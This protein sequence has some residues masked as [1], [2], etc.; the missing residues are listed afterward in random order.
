MTLLSDPKI[1]TLKKKYI[2]LIVAEIDDGIDEAFVDILS[3]LSSKKRISK[4]GETKSEIYGTKFPYLHTIFSF[5]PKLPI[6][7]NY[8]KDLTLEFVIQSEKCLKDSDCSTI[9]SFKTFDNLTD[10]SFNLRSLPELEVEPYFTETNGEEREKIKKEWIKIF[11]ELQ[12]KETDSETV[13]KE[14]ETNFKQIFHSVKVGD[15]L[16]KR[17]KYVEENSSNLFFES[18]SQW[19]NEEVFKSDIES[20][21]SESFNSKNESLRN[22]RHQKNRINLSNLYGEDNEITNILRL[23]KDGKLKYQIIDSNVFPPKITF[24]NQDILED[25]VSQELIKMNYP[26]HWSQDEAEKNIMAMGGKNLNFHFGLVLIQTIWLREHNLVCDLLK[27]ENPTWND[28]RLFQTAR[29]ILIGELNKCV[30][31]DFMNHILFE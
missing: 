27:K 18:F 10:D 6:T 15:S 4:L 19:F 17:K 13:K 28:E 7:N 5:L 1:P 24:K 3:K 8:V 22:D 23:K 31:D 25:E 2:D 21:L 20:F 29:L 30:V 26:K 11:P 9:G 14:K 16:F 12:I